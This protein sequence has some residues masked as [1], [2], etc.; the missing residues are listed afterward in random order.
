MVFSSF[1]ADCG[2]FSLKRNVLFN[3]PI[4]IN[5]S[6]SNKPTNGFSNFYDKFTSYIRILTGPAISKDNS[7]TANPF[8]PIAVKEN[9]SVFKYIDSNSSRAGID[10][11]NK[12]LQSQKIAIIGLGGTGSY[13]LD[14]ISKSSVE[15]IHLFD[16]DVLLNH[17]AFRSP[18][19]VSLDSLKSKP[20]KVEYYKE[21]YSNLRNGIYANNVFID[22]DKLALL[23]DFDY[24]F[25]CLDENEIRFL[26][27]N[28]LS[29][30]KPDLIIGTIVFLLVTQGAFRILKLSK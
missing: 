27:S 26:C 7:I 18:G 6:F 29:S 28:Y 3:V 2:Y 12:K 30:N 25:L 11:V 24:V 15:E 5:F 14:L 19:A 20:K 9:E 8:N 17:N 22:K 21:L 10:S 4:N 23:K 16:A 1:S 13:I